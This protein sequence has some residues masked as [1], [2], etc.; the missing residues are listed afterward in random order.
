VSDRAVPGA[1]EASG[2]PALTDARGVQVGDGNFQVNYHVYRGERLTA[3][4]GMNRPPLVNSF[5]TVESPYRGLGAFGERDAPFFHGR[6]TATGELLGL[7]S[8][9]ALGG[10]LLVVSGVSGAGKSSL[11]RAGVLPRIRAEGL[12]AAPGAARWTALV[13]TPTREPLEQL[14]LQAAG[15][16][17]T[18]AALMR[19]NL[20]AS[21]EGFSTTARQLA[22]R[23]APPDQDGA[24]RLLLIVDQFEQVF[25]QCAD[26]GQRR[27]FAAALC[28]A[29]ATG[30]AL[31]V[32][33]VRADFEARCA[34]LPGL[35]PAV[36]NHRYL[37]TAMDEVELR[38]AIEG[39]VATLAAS[40]GRAL[41]VETSLVDYLVRETVEAPGLSVSGAGALPLLSHALDQAWRNRSG[42]A[43]TLADYE[44]GGRIQGAV[45][46]SADRAFESLTTAQRD[47]ARQVFLRLTTTSD[48]GTAARDRVPRAELL[49]A[50][51]PGRRDDVAGV[52]DAFTAERLI[53][54]AAADVEISHDALL[55]A[56][57]LLR[58]EWLAGSRADLAV[59]SRLRDTARKWAAG[60]G[61]P[62]L[63]YRDE[64]LDEAAGAVRRAAAAPGLHPALGPADEAF[65]QASLQVR[66]SAARRR[67]AVRSSL[68]ALGAC[69]AVAVAVTSVSL[70][71]AKSDLNTARVQQLSAQS[72][73]LR[74]SAPAVSE[75]AA[76]A[77][78]SAAPSDQTRNLAVAAAT[79]PLLEEFDAGIGPVA[80]SPDGAVL[81]VADRYGFS[82]SGSDSAELTLWNMAQRTL[83]GYIRFPEGTSVTSVAFSPV[84][85]GRVATLAVTAANAIAL[86]QVGGPSPQLMQTVPVDGVGSG[87]GPVPIAFD[88]DGTLAVTAAGDVRLYTPAD[89]RYPARPT[90]VIPNT[91]PVDSLSFAPDGSLA[92]G[93]S[94]GVTVYQRA[95]GYS[96][97]S[98]SVGE[99]A[100]N[101]VTCAQ[102]GAGELLTVT[103]QAG[104]VVDRY[105][106]GVLTRVPLL[107]ATTGPVSSAAAEA[108]AETESGVE[109]VAAQSTA[110]SGKGVLAVA[111]GDGLHLFVAASAD[112]SFTDVAAFPYPGQQEPAE[113]D[114]EFTPDGN[115]LVANV[116]GQV[117]AYDT[118]AILGTS[119]TVTPAG[120]PGTSATQVHSG[121]AFDPADTAILAVAKPDAVNLVNVTN[122]RVVALAG[123][124]DATG[125]AFAPDGTLAVAVAGDVRLWPAPLTDPA[126]SRLAA[127]TGRAI[128][129]AFSPAGAM[130]VTQSAR[131]ALIVY[132]PGNFT[133]STPV[134]LRV[135]GAAAADVAAWDPAFGPGGQLAVAVSTGSGPYHVVVFA[136]ASYAE[137]ADISAGTLTPGLTGQVIAFAPDGTLALGTSVGIQLYPPGQYEERHVIAVVNSPAA[138]N[139]YSWLTFTRNGILVSAGPSAGL[140]VW[141]YKTGQDLA[142]LAVTAH[143]S[144][145]GQQI[146]VSPDGR[147]LAYDSG[148]AASASRGAQSGTRVTTVWSAPYLGSNVADGVQSLCRQLGGAPAKA[149]WDDSFASSLPYPQV[150]G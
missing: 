138:T 77:A 99:K 125:V 18:D 6:E 56:W 78:W 122:G 3:T 13:L 102:F 100:G 127:R 12:A 72:M 62:G 76:A 45:E 112:A 129:V 5:G 37:V 149:Q 135:P 49:N 22:L 65:L 109:G 2:R 140:S 38:I 80:V 110:L 75:L 29:A 86:Y 19:A 130:A 108:G 67:T 136:A 148:I 116:G 74:D 32:I 57:P 39:P 33:V 36:R 40:S 104:T 85:R 48:D 20:A 68:A 8:E 9:A 1:G 119:R 17:G 89:G 120:D 97:S 124:A 126:G 71:S 15:L 103:N 55:T 131:P 111:E 106:G 95:N 142:T 113:V 133:A 73:A 23:S 114:V 28:S 101:A 44:R 150:C 64:V 66:R 7:L 88:R 87:T 52:L 21:P 58:D 27:K 132:P 60:G 25:T 93:A 41:S 141:D 145:S 11:L 139:G 70:A 50:A 61:K 53:T 84:E 98:A 30:A 91:L 94:S 10:G 147:Y 14:A 42:P 137:Q 79:N 31:V 115:T 24:G 4:D 123:T 146:A 43:L 69:L 128:S 26:D 144:V 51:G 54:Q 59:M 82:V 81:A 92:V 90:Y 118:R 47:V 117:Y 16:I 83:L 46:A 143:E 107:S 35:A 34:D 105:S 96:R 121:L 134:T 63:L